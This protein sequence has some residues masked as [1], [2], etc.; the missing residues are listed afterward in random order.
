MTSRIEVVGVY[1]IPDAPHA[2]LIEIAVDT[3]PD[4]LDLGAFTQ[5]E[6]GQPRENWQAP[7]MEQWLNESGERIVSEPFDPPPDNLTSSRVVFFLHYV[8]FDRPL[9]TPAG[10]VALPAKAPLPPRLSAVEYEPVD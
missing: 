6:P 10:E 3:R 9:I 2:V 1:E 5:E 7:W 8:S 4:D